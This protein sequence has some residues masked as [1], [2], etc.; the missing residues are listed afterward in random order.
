MRSTPEWRSFW[1]NQRLTSHK[2]RLASSVVRGWRKAVLQ[3]NT[4]SAA[5]V[6]S[7]L[8]CMIYAV[9]P[10]HRTPLHVYS[11]STKIGRN[12]RNFTTIIPQYLTKSAI[13]PAICGILP[14]NFFRD[15]SEMSPQ[16]SGG[17]AYI[18]MLMMAFT[19]YQ[20]HIIR[21]DVQAFSCRK[22]H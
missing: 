21:I 14:R 3:L 1:A 16:V 19:S 15:I 9:R 5:H 4:V 2:I 6:R 22:W 12:F 8:S 10:V 13:F 20:Y 11:T 18:N 7:V 17:T